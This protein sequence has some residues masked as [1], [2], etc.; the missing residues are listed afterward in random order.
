MRRIISLILAIAVL[1]TC[2]I[3]TGATT[4]SGGTNNPLFPDEVEH[5]TISGFDSLD[6]DF[7]TMVYYLKILCDE[8][9]E[10]I[11]ALADRVYYKN[12]LC[13]AVDAFEKLHSGDG[14][15]TFALRSG[16]IKYINPILPEGVFADVEIEACYRIGNKIIARISFEDIVGKCTC[17]VAAYNSDGAMCSL[18]SF[19]ASYLD[20]YYEIELDANG[21][22]AVKVFFLENTQSLKPLCEAKV[23]YIPTEYAYLLSVNK[24]DGEYEFEMFTAGGE[25]KKFA[26]AEELVINEEAFI[27]GDGGV[28]DRLEFSAESANKAYEDEINA[29]YHQ[30]VM[31]AVNENEE[32][33]HID[34]VVSSVNK[35]ISTL[36]NDG[37]YYASYGYKQFKMS[38]R[39]FEDFKVSS[40]TKIIFVPDDR[41]ET[42]SYMAYSS[43]RKP[44]IHLKSYHVEAYGLSA[45]RTAS[46]LLVY[47]ANDRLT[48]R[49]DSPMM[50]VE[51]KSLTK[52]GTVIKGYTGTSYSLKHVTVSDEVES[53]ASIGKGDVI[54]YITDDSSKMTDYR[55][56]FD[57]SSPV[58]ETPC[59]DIDSAISSRILE[60]KATSTEPVINYPQASF[61]LQYGTV[62]DIVLSKEG[63]KI[64]VVPTIAEDNC[65]MVTEGNGVVTWDIEDSVK[66][67]KYEEGNVI[68]EADLT[69]IKIGETRVVAYSSGGKL[70][71]IYIV[72]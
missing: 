13:N 1:F 68:T 40:D 51:S 46:L 72:D 71:M 53:V 27:D 3:T 61:R 48:Y 12:D 22:E 39:T 10:Y 24:K 38:A 37:K 25:V 57:A 19:E 4:I 14:N 69:K 2:S 23:C 54:R 50:I 35:E 28:T 15:I 8:G 9:T 20:S 16:K 31:Y 60:V 6:G 44:F 11:Y 67:Y 33:T 45:S 58:Q 30:P 26:C 42:D 41:S 18:T 55:V 5:G 64:T 34:T 7:G 43:Y 66:I 36:V 49:Y 29:T 56:W 63:D 21:G 59:D 70:R 32:I 65:D 52:D 47:K 62:A 17:I